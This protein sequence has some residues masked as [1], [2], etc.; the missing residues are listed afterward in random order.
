MSSRF[1]IQTRKFLGLLDDL[2]ITAGNIPDDETFNGIHISSARGPW[3]EEPGD[4]DLIVG[5]SGNGEVVGNTWLPGIGSIEAGFWSNVNVKNIKYVFTPLAKKHDKDNAD[6]PHHVTIVVDNG[7]ITII[8]ET[9][10]E[11]TELQ[12]PV[13]DNDFPLEGVSK[14]ITGQSSVNAPRDKNNE[15]G[16]DGALTVWT[17]ALGLVL[18]VAKRRKQFLR[19]YR[20]DHAAK[21][22]LAQIGD[23]WRGA[24]KPHVPEIGTMDVDQPDSDLFL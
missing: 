16:E 8:E 24:I 18:S 20:G 4:T 22:Y 14:W 10:D 21:I 1:T 11:P 19:L 3:E 7:F 6:D 9:A 5:I 13:E 23:T 2:L 12:F 17:P 15:P